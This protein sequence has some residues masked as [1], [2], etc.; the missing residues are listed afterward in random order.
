M[1]RIAAE[2][3]LDTYA[4]RPDFGSVVPDLE[5]PVLPPDAITD[6]WMDPHDAD[7]AETA[8]RWKWLGYAVDV[9]EY[10]LQYARNLGYLLRQQLVSAKLESSESTPDATVHQVRTGL[11]GEN[12]RHAIL[13]TRWLVRPTG[14]PELIAAWPEP[15]RELP[16]TSSSESSNR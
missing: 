3:D 16:A 12:G 8:R 6:P 13:V 2:V 7:G 5:Q 11:I 15:S 10:R 1:L 9:P 14:R 4:D